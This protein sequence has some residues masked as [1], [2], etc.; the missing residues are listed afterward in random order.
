[1]HLAALFDSRWK[2]MVHIGQTLHM[3]GGIIIAIVCITLPGSFM[4][5]AQIM[6]LSMVRLCT[7]R[8]HS[9]RYLTSVPR[10]GLQISHHCRLPTFN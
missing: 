2:L 3:I 5:R 7:P 8:V 1:M 4:T 10:P 6:A 9:L